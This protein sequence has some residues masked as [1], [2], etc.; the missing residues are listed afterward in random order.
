MRDFR[1]W[2]CKQPAR[3]IYWHKAAGWHSPTCG[4]C[5]VPDPSRPWSEMVCLQSDAA[6]KRA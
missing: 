2:G 4:I 3:F 1:C 5:P 6:V